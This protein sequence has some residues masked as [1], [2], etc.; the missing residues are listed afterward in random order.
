MMFDKLKAALLTV[1]VPVFHFFAAEASDKYIVWAEDGQGESLYGGDEMAAQVIQGSVD[2]F[3][4][5]EYDGNVPKIQA[6]L[7]ASGA[8]WSLG[9]VQYEAADVQTVN[10][11]IKFK[12]GAGFIHYEWIWET[13]R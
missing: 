11:I 5:E 1:G 8:A 6:A 13:T 2:Y 10:S 4:T 7:E 3:T 9:S 12:P